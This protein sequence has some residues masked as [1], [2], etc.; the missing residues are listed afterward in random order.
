MLSRFDKRKLEANKIARNVLAEYG[1]DY[2]AASDRVLEFVG[3][4]R[5]LE[6]LVLG[7]MRRLTTP[8]K[9]KAA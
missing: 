4:Q 2:E 6:R 1:Y 9:R 8:Q 3:G 5:W 7:E